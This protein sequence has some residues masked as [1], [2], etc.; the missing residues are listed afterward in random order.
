[1]QLGFDSFH[2]A[3]IRLSE[4]DR[5]GPDQRPPGTLATTFLPALTR[6]VSA[7]IAPRGSWPGLRWSRRGRIARALCHGSPTRSWGT[8]SARRRSGDPG[9]AVAQTLPHRRHWGNSVPTAASGPERPPRIRTLDD[10]KAGPR[11]WL[12]LLVAISAHQVLARLLLTGG[13][14]QKSQPMTA[15]LPDP[16]TSGTLASSGHPARRGCC[17]LKAATLGRTRTCMLLGEC[18]R[19]IAARVEDRRAL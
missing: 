5:S 3:H 2:P 8:R 11:A 4:G 7:L 16:R 12:H 9:A 6:S 13:S 10:W 1:V 15:A 14:M 18:R 19:V 17:R